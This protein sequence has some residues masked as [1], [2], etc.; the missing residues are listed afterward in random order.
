MLHLL[1]TAIA[2]DVLNNRTAVLVE[3][4]PSKYFTI[5]PVHCLI[6]SMLRHKAASEALGRTLQDLL[7]NQVWEESLLYLAIFDKLFLSFQ[8]NLRR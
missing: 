1:F 6:V 8:E 3:V 4:L 7:R 5:V 2:I